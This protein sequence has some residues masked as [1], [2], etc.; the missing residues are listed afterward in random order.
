M[1][2]A[3]KPATAETGTSLLRLKALRC[4]GYTSTAPSRSK[5]E[6]A[7]PS[8]CPAGTRSPSACV[9]GSIATVIG[10]TRGRGRGWQ[11]RRRIAV[12]CDHG[13]RERKSPVAGIQ[14]PRHAARKPPPAAGKCR[15]VGSQQDP[16][17]V[18]NRLDHCR[19]SPER[20]QGLRDFRQYLC[21]AMLFR[22]SA[23]NRLASSRLPKLAGQ[24]GRFGGEIIVEKISFRSVKEDA[25]PITSLE[26]T[27]GA[28]MSDWHGIQR[29]EDIGPERRRFTYTVLRCRM[30]SMATALSDAF[31]RR[32]VKSA[33]INPSASA[34]TSSS[35][36]S[37]RQKYAPSTWKKS[38]GRL[39]EKADQ[40]RRPVSLGGR[41]RKIVRAVSG[42]RRPNEG[43]ICPAPSNSRACNIREAPPST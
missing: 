4:R 36:E 5:S 32:P 27:S 7:R 37:H 29:R 22:E 2:T 12:L 31:K 25:A 10:S 39:A 34:P 18:R 41:L 43:R 16:Q 3:P 24:N 20:L 30:A 9:A 40:T 19:K 17:A 1:A 8:A 23:V 6:R 26:T 38:A 11:D 13:G 15:P 21:A 14:R 42:K 28:A 33:A 35:A